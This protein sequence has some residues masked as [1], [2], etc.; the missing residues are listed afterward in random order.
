GRTFDR[1][2]GS[3]RHLSYPLR[4]LLFRSVQQRLGGS[5]TI[6]GSSGAFLPPTLQQAWGGLGVTVLQGYG[7]SENGFGTCT[8]REDHGLGTV[9]RAMPPVQVRIAGDGEV[10]FAGPTLFKG[11][12]QEPQATARAIDPD[13]WYHTRDSRHL[14]PR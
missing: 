9:G 2:G 5:L 14:N 10:L 12:W 8:T 11:Y 7:S 1:L 3:A 13:G 6:F 4:R